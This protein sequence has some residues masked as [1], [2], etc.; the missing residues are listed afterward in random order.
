M[1]HVHAT[2][3]TGNRDVNIKN[4]MRQSSGSRGSS[5][6][7]LSLLSRLSF[8]YILALGGLVYLIRILNHLA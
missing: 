6:H 4:P 7:H 8:I 2:R 1:I 3:I 5:S